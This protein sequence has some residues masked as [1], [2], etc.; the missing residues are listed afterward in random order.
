MD[1][2]LAETSIGIT[3]L[4]KNPSAVIRDAGADTVVILH[5]NKPSA[6]LVPARSYEALMDVLDDLQLLPVV[7]ERMAAWQAD[8]D[9]VIDV[10]REELEKIARDVPKRAARAAGK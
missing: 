5:H 9:K 3:E 1:A 4:K 2:V 10:S 8:P 6:Y 7:R